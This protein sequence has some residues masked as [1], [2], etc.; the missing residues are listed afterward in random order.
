LNFL[1]VFIISLKVPTD[2]GMCCAFNKEEA[3][4]IFV[5]SIYTNTLKEFNEKDKRAA[6]KIN[7]EQPFGEQISSKTIFIKLKHVL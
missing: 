1:I 5:E 7:D 4:K 2:E 6:F 3:D